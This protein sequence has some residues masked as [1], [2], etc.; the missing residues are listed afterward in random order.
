V[1]GGGNNYARGSSSVV[2]GGG[3]ID[4]DSNS[5]V[6]NFSTISGGTRNVAT[7][8]YSTIPGGINNRAA[9]K[10]S[11]AAGRRAKADHTGAFV[12]ADSADVDFIST[13][14][15]QFLIRASGGVGIGTAVP[16]AKLHVA[17]TSLDNS[18]A[19]HT[20][21]LTETHSEQSLWHTFDDGKP[22]YGIGFRR[23]W[24]PWTT[25]NTNNI[26]GIYAYGAEGFRGGLVFKTNNVGAANSEPN[27]NALVIRPDGNVG[28]GTKSPAAKLQVIGDVSISG[29][30]AKGSGSFKIDH[31]IDPEH[32][33][34][35][36]S[37]IESPDMKNIYDG[38]AILDANGEAQVQLPSY[39][40]VLNSD[41]RYQLTCVGGYAPVFISEE[42]ND[43]IFKIAG[44][45]SGMKVSWQVTGIRQD[46]YAK[47]HR[48]I[49]E[50]DKN[51]NEV[52]KYIYPK[53]YGLP[54]T[55]RIGFEDYK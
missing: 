49:P 19:K 30:L 31:P 28:I 50:V 48:I 4:G 16:E 25:N 18:L 36:H 24:Q 7:G 32:K 27:V 42:V 12:W 6:G 1:G 23:V 21:Y 51:E 55:M 15:N 22:Y 37:F 8:D 14:S 17:K 3:G 5:A 20:V 9:G 53:E 52:G 46:P 43:N 44:G 34:L 40:Q 45:K 35:Y 13:G 54:E 29:A 26:A 11:F 10:Y 33:Y 39:F 38:I 47:A 41:F 2:A